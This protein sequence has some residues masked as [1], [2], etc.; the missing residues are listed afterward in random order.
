MT[1]LPFFGNQSL[2]TLRGEKAGPLLGLF[3]IR[4]SHAAMEGYSLTKCRF[5]CDSGGLIDRFWTSSR[6]QKGLRSRLLMSVGWWHF[7]VLMAPPFK[8]LDFALIDGKLI[9]FPW[10]GGCHE[11]RGFVLGL[12]ALACLCRLSSFTPSPSSLQSLHQ[13]RERFV[14]K[15]HVILRRKRDA[16]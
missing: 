4:N 16:T 9:L 11:Q 7:C 13:T 8:Y 1:P 14:M 5:H 2:S 10:V 15:T 3:A 6:S 12:L